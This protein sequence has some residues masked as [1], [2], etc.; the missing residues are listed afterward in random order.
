MLLDLIP[1]R[2]L[3]GSNYTKESYLILI[4]KN[5]LFWNI[6][7][8]LLCKIVIN[9]EDDSVSSHRLNYLLVNALRQVRRSL[10]EFQFT[11]ILMD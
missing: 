11:N 3:F 7:C 8:A 6:Y 9:F 5:V 10:R 4:E 1:C 2:L